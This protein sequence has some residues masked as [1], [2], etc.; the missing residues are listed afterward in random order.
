MRDRNRFPPPDKIFLPPRCQFAPSKRTANAGLHLKLQLRCSQRIAITDQRNLN[1]ARATVRPAG[2]CCM[3]RLHSLFFQRDS[4]FCHIDGT[5]HSITNGQCYYRLQDHDS[6]CEPEPPFVDNPLI[7]RNRTLCSVPAS[8]PTVLFKRY[9]PLYFT[10]HKTKCLVIRR[11]RAAQG[12]FPST[13]PSS[14]TF[15]MWLERELTELFGKRGAVIVLPTLLL[16]HA[17]VPPCISHLAKKSRSKRS[18]HLII[19][20]SACGRFER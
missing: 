10:R 6:H 8:P 18:R 13:F 11:R 1:L 4:R 16:T 17:Q 14:M 20:C 15:K 19:P 3:R 5:K 9:Q 12:R 7:L 2:L